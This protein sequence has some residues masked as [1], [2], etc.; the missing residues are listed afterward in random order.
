MVIGTHEF[1][2]IVTKQAKFLNKTGFYK[3]GAHR[4]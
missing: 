1:L 4:V 3:T 2:S